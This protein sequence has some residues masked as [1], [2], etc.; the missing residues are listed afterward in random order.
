MATWGREK[1]LGGEAQF[2]QDSAWFYVSIER[3]MQP[4]TVLLSMQ[5]P[6]FSGLE[7]SFTGMQV[8]AQVCCGAAVLVFVVG[9]IG[10]MVRMGRMRKVTR[11]DTA[12]LVSFRDSPHLLAL[13]QDGLVFPGSPKAAVY[14][15]ACREL[16]WHL[17]GTDSVDKSFV[18]KLRTAGRITPG[19]AE[20]V[21]RTTGHVAGE[22]ARSFTERLEG[23]GL[24]SL[25]LIGLL[26]FLVCVLDGLGAGNF[27]T[28]MWT[29]ALWPL[30]LSVVLFLFGNLLR[31]KT[32]R[33]VQK[34]AVGVKDFA[35]EVGVALDRM[36]V[37][38]RQAMESLPSLGSMGL[39]DGPNFSLPPGES[40]RT[41]APAAQRTL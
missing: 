30:V 20:A 5:S 21:Q 9:A 12:F 33:E 36:F 14:Q 16:S 19:Q 1:N 24:R 8:N 35:V 18:A 28:G 37:D 26:G 22:L 32:A 11:M 23:L 7:K 39:L 40:M 34:T 29:S 25:P 41:S 31:Q 3:S 2:F 13:F 15:N 17:L 27:S 4:A 6:L 10:L 38:H